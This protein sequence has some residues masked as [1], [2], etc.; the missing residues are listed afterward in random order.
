MTPARI[1][2]AVA[3]GLLQ[4]VVG[5]VLAFLS[6]ES[7]G[8]ATGADFSVHWALAGPALGV[9]ATIAFVVAYVSGRRDWMRIGLIASVSALTLAVAAS[10]VAQTAALGAVL[11]VLVQLVP[12]VLPPPVDGP[13]D[14]ERMGSAH[15]LP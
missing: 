4:A 9:L 1:L 5:L 6:I 10:A 12:A 15:P 3:A 14:R 8:I 2:A 13:G 7:I 11:F